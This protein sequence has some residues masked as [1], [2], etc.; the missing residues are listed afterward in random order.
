VFKPLETA[1]IRTI[2]AFLNSDDGG[3]PR[4][5]EPAA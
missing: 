4:G 2:A 1:T 5:V 3:R